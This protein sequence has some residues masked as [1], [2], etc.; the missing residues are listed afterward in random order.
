MYE[1]GPANLTSGHERAAN[2]FKI[3]FYE[4]GNGSVTATDVVGVGVLVIRFSSTKTLLFLNR[5]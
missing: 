3:L 4:H 5:L 2:L 1:L